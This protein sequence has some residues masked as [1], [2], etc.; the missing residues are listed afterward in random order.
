ML[1]AVAVSSCADRLD[2][3]EAASEGLDVPYVTAILPGDTDTKTALSYEDNAL[4]ASWVAGDSFNVVPNGYMRYNYG[5]YTLGQGGGRTADFACTKSVS[6]TGEEYA[7]FYPSSIIDYASWSGFSYLGQ[8]QKKSDPMA[9][10]SQYYCMAVESLSDYSTVDFSKATQS[11]CMRFSLSGM[12]F[13]SPSKI[14]VSLIGSTESFATTNDYNMLTGKYRV[15]H[16]TDVAYESVK[17]AKSLELGLEGYGDETAIV[18]YMMMSDGHVTIPSGAKV[19]VK[20]TCSDGVWYHDFDITSAMTLTGGKCHRITVD[21]DWTKSDADYTE[22]SFDGDVVTVQ[23]TGT[24]LDLVFMGDGFIAED[25]TS[26]KYEALLKKSIDDFFSVQPLKYF[27]DKFNIYIVKAVSPQRTNA[28][29]TGANGAS[30][31]GT[32]TKFECVFTPNATRISGN[33]DM[34]LA[35]ASKAL[36][37]DTQSRLSNANI[38]VIANQEC[39]SGTCYNY[40]NTSVSTDYGEAMSIAYFGLGTTAAEGTQLIVHETDGHGFGKLADEYYYETSGNLSTSLWT[41]LDSK[42]KIGLYRN[43]DKHIDSNILSQLG[44]GYELTTKDNVYWHNLFGT[45]NN[46]ESSSVESLGVFKGGYVY[47]FGFCRPTEDGAKSIMFKN[48]GIFNAISRY[49]IWYR[50]NSLLGNISGNKFDDSSVLAQFLAWDKEVFLPTLSTKSAGVP[51]SIS[52]DSSPLDPPVNY[53]G[54]WENGK[55]IVEKCL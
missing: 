45:S 25:I 32:E 9:H 19:R 29:T 21:S 18:A 2:A 23:E 22:Y 42:H 39:R 48:T 13:K 17:T 8:V 1:A 11:S 44:S 40:W 12:T 20:V 24:G 31:T 14:T 30:N 4:K 16:Y 54:H 26:G 33:D 10:L 49:Q 50:A 28:V 15:T 53:M 46:Y 35:Y 55:F 38:V 27:R 36:T 3:P 43:V 5:T 34:A 47:S 41:D 37:G 6:A 51:A 7:V 52:R